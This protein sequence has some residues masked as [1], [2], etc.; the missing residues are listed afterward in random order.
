MAN[1]LPHDLPQDL[2]QDDGQSIRL[3]P[4][5]PQRRL[6]LLHGWG[7]DADDLLNWAPPC[8]RKMGRLAKSA[9]WP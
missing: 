3:E 4:A 8:W 9:W 5:Q 2:P 1:F 6:V 7:A